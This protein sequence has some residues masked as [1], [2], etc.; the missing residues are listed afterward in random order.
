LS[1]LRAT[2]TRREPFAAKM[3]ASALPIPDDAP[4]TSTVS[5]VS[6]ID[7]LA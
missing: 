4:V 7:R 3:S 5:G 1:A 6:G 2:S